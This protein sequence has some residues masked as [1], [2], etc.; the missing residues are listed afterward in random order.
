MQPIVAFQGLGQRDWV[1]LY[2]KPKFK[3]AI[4]RGNKALRQHGIAVEGRPLNLVEACRKGGL[5]LQEHSQTCW[6]QPCI[7]LAS[8]VLWDQWLQENPGAKPILLGFSFGEWSAAT[9]AGCIDSETGLLTAAMRGIFTSR[10]GGSSLLVSVRTGSLPIQ[11]LR[12]RCKRVGSVWLA[13]VNSSQQG[14]ISGQ[15]PALQELERSLKR[16]LPSLKTSDLALGGAFHTPLMRIPKKQLERW[17]EGVE[18]QEAKLPLLL[19]ATGEITT[20]PRNIK[21]MLLRQLSARL[22]FKKRAE[23]IP[24]DAV[25]HELCLGNPIIGPLTR[26]THQVKYGAK[27]GRIAAVP[28]FA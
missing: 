9:A 7:F 20:D 11:R 5:V 18:F 1:A 6:Q 19:N 25:L 22:N 23:E 16:N 17:L 3:E 24:A 15:T 27:A 28:F 13:N 12:Y 8:M 14:L 10:A 21:A 2:K 4:Q 26:Q